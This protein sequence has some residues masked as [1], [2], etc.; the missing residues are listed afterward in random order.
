VQLRGL[1]AFAQEPLATVLFTLA[2]GID[3]GAHREL[4]RLA[5]GSPL[6]RFAPAE[7]PE[8]EDEEGG[9]QLRLPRALRR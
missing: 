8:E 4:V 1:A 3:F 7:A 5:P 9:A 6:M 2:K